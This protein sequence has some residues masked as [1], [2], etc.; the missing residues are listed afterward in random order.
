MRDGGEQSFKW[1]AGKHECL[2]LSPGNTLTTSAHNFRSKHV[3]KLLPFGHSKGPPQ[4]PNSTLR[5]FQGPLYLES[6]QII[7]DNQL[8]QGYAALS[9][10]CWNQQQIRTFYKKATKATLGTHTH[11]LSVM[12]RYPQTCKHMYVHTRKYI[13]NTKSPHVS[14][15]TPQ[16][17]RAH[18][19]LHPGVVQK[20]TQPMPKP[21][22]S[23]LLP[24]ATGTCGGAETLETFQ[25]IQTF[26]LSLLKFHVPLACLFFSLMVKQTQQNGSFPLERADF[27]QIYFRFFP[28]V[29]PF[30]HKAE[31]L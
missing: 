13:Q 12:Y 1:V 18:T 25:A 26:S 20:R 27:G 10:Y 14:P 2:D 22:F 28:P 11:T 30:C 19:Y 21:V 9:L 3:L 29:L 23:L 24:H 15:G 5:D 8:H 4:Q 17:Q 7:G 31:Q 6:A 16:T